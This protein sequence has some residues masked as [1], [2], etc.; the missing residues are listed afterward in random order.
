MTLNVNGLNIQIQRHIVR[1]DWKK[2][3]PETS[4]IE[5]LKTQ[6]LEWEILKYLSKLDR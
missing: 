2:Q 6:K 4:S 1:V 3:T 5:I